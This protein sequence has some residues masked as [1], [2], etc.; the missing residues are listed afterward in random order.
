MSY[1][2][3]REF[4][5]GDWKAVQLYSGGKYTG[6]TKSPYLWHHSHRR[7]QMKQWDGTSYAKEWVEMVGKDQ[8]CLRCGAKPPKA[9]R[10]LMK[11]RDSNL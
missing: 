7:L 8:K 10:M 1:H 11:L 4:E 9:V 5:F 6:E 3:K 2:H